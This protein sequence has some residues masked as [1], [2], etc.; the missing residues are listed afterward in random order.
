MADKVPID[1]VGSHLPAQIDLFICVASFESR[2]L[3]IAQRV[4]D[5][6]KHAIVLQNA[7][8]SAIAE[9]N[10]ERLRGLFEG[11]I[12]EHQ[13]SIASPTGTADLLWSQVVSA[14]SKVD[15]GTV[16]VD[17]TTFTHEQLLILIALIASIELKAQLLLVYNGAGE[18]S[19]NTD[20]E[21]VWLSRGVKRIRSVL[22]FPGLQLPTRKLHL[23]ILVGFE[24]ERAQALIEKMEPARLSLGVG[25]PEQSV[26]PQHHS[27][28]QRF[29]D[30][31]HAFLAKQSANQARVEIFN[32]SCVD[33]NAVR[34]R[35]LGQT[36]AY[37]EFNTVV[38][39]M[40]TKLSTVGVAL[41]ALAETSIQ[42]A[43]SE[44]E[45]YNEAGYSTPGPTAMV[46]PFPQGV[47]SS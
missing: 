30:R 43:Y 25:H 11:R 8:P 18:Y 36:R 15:N 38:C 17:I 10:S 26:S 24:I 42:I 37:G 7:R 41:A 35:I 12:R 13:I 9:L 3:S 40:N 31:L 47:N 14:I 34:D 23:I 28:N 33:P 4:H 22:G 20:E 21:H 44:A 19:T 6:T 46:V 1:D 29:V 16:V 45:E 5:R 39:P 2:C 27:R 32:F